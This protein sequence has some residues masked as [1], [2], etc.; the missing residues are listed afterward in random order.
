MFY[1]QKVDSSSRR[2]H[3]AFQDLRK[4]QDLRIILAIEGRETSQNVLYNK[5]FK[6]KLE[7]L[8]KRHRA[9]RFRTKNLCCVSVYA[10][11]GEMPWKE[12]RLMERQSVFKVAL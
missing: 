4:V 1:V 7:F 10:V 6:F 9:A 5:L 12:R 2:R 8:L 11:G 3:E